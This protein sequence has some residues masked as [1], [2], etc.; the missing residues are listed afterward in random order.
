MFGTVCRI[1]SRQTPSS[2]LKEFR[3]ALFHYAN[4]PLDAAPFRV[5]LQTLHRF[6]YRL[7]RE[8]KR[9]VV[10][11]NHPARAQVQERLYGVFR[12]GVHSAKRIGMISPDGKQR[13]LRLEALADLTEAVEV[14]GVS[15]VINRLFAC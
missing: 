4:L 6:V 3:H 15:G 7:V 5:G 1:Y 2:L 14:R 8:A 13:D 12:A 9:P 11:R 10:H